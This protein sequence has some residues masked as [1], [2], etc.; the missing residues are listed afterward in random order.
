MEPRQDNPTAGYQAPG[1]AAQAVPQYQYVG[2][3]LQGP[4]AYAPAPNYPQYLNAT[5]P[6]AVPVAVPATLPVSQILAAGMFGLVVAG[7]GAMGANLHRVG[8]GTMT[9]GEALGNSLAKGAAGGVAAAAAAG[10]TANLT[11]GGLAGLAVTLGVAT[12]VSYLLST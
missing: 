2:A 5:Q 3:P 10:A 8:D 12:G 6:T 11:G 4:P 1:A 9:M 7:T